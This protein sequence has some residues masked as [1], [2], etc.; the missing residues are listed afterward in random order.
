[1]HTVDP[2]PVYD[3]SHWWCATW[4]KVQPEAVPPVSRYY[5]LCLQQDLWGQWELLRC[6]GRIGRKP[7]RE[8]QESV[9]SPE[10]AEAIRQQ[11]Q[12]TRRQHRYV[13]V[14]T[15]LVALDLVNWTTENTA[16]RS[17]GKSE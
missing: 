11:V 7:T 14:E 17:A 16:R 1:M 9:D 12:K 15:P 10:V 5:R 3:L 8:Q 4:Q 2:D 6:W 13:P